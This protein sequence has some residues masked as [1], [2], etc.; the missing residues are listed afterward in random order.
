MY[1]ST[2]ML[3]WRIVRRSVFK[4][5]A[6]FKTEGFVVLSNIAAPH[7]KR[8]AWNGLPP[9]CI[10]LRSFA[11]RRSGHPLPTFGALERTEFASRRWPRPLGTGAE[12]LM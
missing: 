4:A 7:F 5:L 8:G 11:N 12:T 1:G 9:Y 10:P 6:A 2:T 3:N